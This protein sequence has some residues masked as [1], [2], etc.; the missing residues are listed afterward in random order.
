VGGS[1][2]DIVAGKIV[3]ILR[4]AEHTPGKGRI[5]HCFDLAFWPDFAGGLA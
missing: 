2:F 4:R 3:Q 1:D 5:C